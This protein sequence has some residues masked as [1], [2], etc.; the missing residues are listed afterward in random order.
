MA[1]KQVVAEMQ[2]DSAPITDNQDFA[3]EQQAVETPE[4]GVEQETSQH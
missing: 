3:A 1:E 2:Q 4:Q